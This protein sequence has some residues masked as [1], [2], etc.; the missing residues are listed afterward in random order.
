MY[1][2]MDNLASLRLHNLFMPQGVGDPPPESNPNGNP[3]PPPQ[4]APNPTPQDSGT[5]TDQ[6]YDVQQRMKQLYTPSTSAQTAYSD[7]AKNIPSV[8]T[9]SRMRRIGAMIAG[10]NAP[11]GGAAYDTASRI[12]ND[13][14]TQA[15]NRYRQQVSALQP[16]A[17]Q[18]QSQNKIDQQ[19]AFKVIADEQAAK[20]EADATAAGLAK[21]KDAQAKIKVSA[22]RAAAYIFK[23]QNPQWKATVGNDGQL[24]Y[25]NPQDPTAEPVYTG[26]NTI[27]DLTDMDKM[28]LGIAA[29]Q[30]IT[31][32]QQAGANQRNQ[33]TIAGAAARTDAQQTGANT[34]AAGAQ[35]GATDRTNIR[36]KG[37]TDR[38][39][40]PPPTKTVTTTISPD[41]QSKTI[42]TGT[43]RTTDVDLSKGKNTTPAPVPKSDPGTVMMK[44]PVTGKVGR[45]KKENVA[46]AQKNG[47]TIVT[48]GQ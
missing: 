31:N 28:N 6:P 4:P 14:N 26:I 23:Q 5:L 35:I 8:N 47:Y 12:V 22:D 1:P 7:A 18:E 46:E 10:L 15:M 24:I 21:E 29:R 32:T 40:T 3:L 39:N 45:V 20:K 44:H 9:P 43:A 16:A 38:R 48:D 2:P 25:T 37:A 34:R 13:P 17:A 36:E 30:Q 33:A 27:H 11:N 41:K 19:E 42:T